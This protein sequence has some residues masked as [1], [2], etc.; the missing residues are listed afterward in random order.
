M[1][2]PIEPPHQT[3]SSADPV[4][5]IGD[6]L[7]EKATKESVR[8]TSLW[9]M[10]PA[11]ATAVL[12]SGA[13]AWFLISRG[14]STATGM[15]DPGSGR[16]T[17]AILREQ[18]ADC[19]PCAQRNG[20]FDPA[21]LG[22]TCEG[23]SGQATACGTGVTETAICLKTLDDIFNSKCAATMQLTPCLCGSTDHAACL[24]GTADPSGPI[25]PDYTCDFKTTSVVKIVGSFTDQ[26]LGAGQAN[27]LVQCL[28]A[29]NCG[30]F[31]Q[32]DN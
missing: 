19:L 11:V 32:R 17:D 26:T 8:A 3:L 28:G 30:C 18:G 2:H 9:G 10:W 29:Y 16:S 14:G 21:Q 23:T 15:A 27:A 24:S 1:T 20:C 4:Q 12:I 22:G 6:G 25:D 5:A 7:A 13:L 31:G